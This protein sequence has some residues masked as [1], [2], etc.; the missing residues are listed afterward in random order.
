MLRDFNISGR[1]NL[2]DIPVLMHMLQFWRVSS[3]WQSWKSNHACAYYFACKQENSI[4]PS[5]RLL[6][7]LVLLQQPSTPVSVHPILDSYYLHCTFFILRYFLLG[8]FTI[9]WPASIAYIWFVLFY[10]PYIHVAVY[11]IPT[12]QTKKG[13]LQTEFILDFSSCLFF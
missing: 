8:S 10:S 11:E 6:N 7:F 9:F 12:G 4:L 13:Y 1:I 5:V 2:L 3:L